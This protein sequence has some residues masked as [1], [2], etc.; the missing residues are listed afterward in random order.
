MT[1]RH[2]NPCLPYL[3]LPVNNLT[4]RK[5]QASIYGGSIAIAS[6]DGGFSALKQSNNLETAKYN[7]AKKTSL[8]L[9]KSPLCDFEL[10]EVVGLALKLSKVQ[11]PTKHISLYGH[12]GDGFLRVKWPNQQCQSTALIST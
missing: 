8:Y 6:D 10:F 9:S 12:I 5:K 2:T 1:R 7:S 4:Y 11:R 3:T